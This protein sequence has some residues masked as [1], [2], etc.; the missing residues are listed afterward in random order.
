MV[1][2]VVLPLA[3]FK[4]GNKVVKAFPLVFVGEAFQINFR[5]KLRQIGYGA[6]V[7]KADLL[8]FKRFRLRKKAVKGGKHNRSGALGLHYNPFRKRLAESP[9]RLYRRGVALF[10][11]ACYFVV[12]RGYK[13]VSSACVLRVGKYPFKML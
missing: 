6:L 7:R 12:K 5:V 8:E 2:A 9:A 13:A 3:A 4:V 1:A 10:A 11:L